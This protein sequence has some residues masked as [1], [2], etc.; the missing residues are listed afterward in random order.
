LEAE[1]RSLRNELQGKTSLISELE[2]RN[3]ELS[4]ALTTAWNEAATPRHEIA[5]VPPKPA[6]P[7]AYSPPPQAEKRAML[8][9]APSSSSSARTTQVGLKQSLAEIDKLILK[10]KDLIDSLKGSKKGVSVRAQPLVSS[11]GDSLDTLRLKVSSLSANDAAS[12]ESGIADIRA[13]LHEDI[14]LMKRL[15]G[16]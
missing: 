3:N 15:T 2:A 10:R 5:A 12:V 6:P 14:S 11:A 8:S 7:A 4:S 13:L 16:G 9:A 1:V